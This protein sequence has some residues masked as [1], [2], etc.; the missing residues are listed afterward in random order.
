MNDVLISYSELNLLVRR[1]TNT[2]EELRSSGDRSRDLERA[3]A[4]PYFRSDLTVAASEAERQW[5]IKRGNLAD[6]LEAIRDKASEVYEGFQ[7]F[8]DEA[9]SAFENSQQ[10]CVP[11]SS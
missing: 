2:V 5:S 8:E 11:A 10:E 7:Q 1:L 3:I 9:A 4:M 6:E